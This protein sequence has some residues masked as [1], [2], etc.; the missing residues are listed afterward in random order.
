LSSILDVDEPSTRSALE[1]LSHFNRLHYSN[2][3]HFLQYARIWCQLSDFLYRHRSL[4]LFSD[5]FEMLFSI[6]ERG[7]SSNV[8]WFEVVR[9]AEELS[10]LVINHLVKELEVPL[11]GRVHGYFHKALHM[12]KERLGETMETIK[13]TIGVC[14]FT[15]K[16]AARHCIYL[17]SYCPQAMQTIHNRYHTMRTIG[18]WLQAINCIHREQ[19]TEACNWLATAASIGEREKT[20]A[21]ATPMLESVRLAQLYCLVHKSLQDNQKAI[22]MAYIGQLRVLVEKEPDRLQILTPLEQLAASLSGSVRSAIPSS[23]SILLETSFSIHEN[24]LLQGTS[25]L[26]PVVCRFRVLPALREAAFRPT[27]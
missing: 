23:N 2:H 25:P 12:S 1:F 17:E 9:A 15:S 19:Y 14:H 3:L 20:T 6:P 22:A 24:A 21:A 13:K 7:E 16:V 10:A 26:L 4:Q 18:C 8:Y 5:K 11:D 27:T